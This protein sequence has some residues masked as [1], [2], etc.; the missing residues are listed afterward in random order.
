MRILTILCVLFPVLAGA[1]LFVW[2][3]QDRKLRNRYAITAVGINAV[4]VLTT[5]LLSAVNGADSM[6]VHIADLSP[7]LSIAFRPDGVS[8]VFGCII[9]VLWPVTTVYA[10]SYMEHEG[11]ENMFFGFFL[12]TFG[13]VAGI[14]YSANFFTLYLCYEFMTLV[15]LPLVMHE[16]DDKARAA[17]KKYV[18]YSMTGAAL[19]FIC[20]M[21]FLRYA[22]TLAFRYGGILNMEKVKGHEKEL[23]T[24]FVLGFFG[25]GVKAAIFPF[26][27]WLPTA[28][29]A[30]TPVT[31]LLH[32]VAVVKAGAFAVMRLIYFGFG[33]D[34]LRGTWAQHV[35][36]CAAAFTVMFGT[37]MAL[38]QDHLKRRLAYH[39]V[40]N[41]SYIILGF[42]A[43]SPMGLL[44]GLLHL[45]YH[46]A[47]KITLFFCAGAILHNNGLE[48]V[49][50]MEGIHKKMPVT[51]ATF[52]VAALALMG[53]PPFGAFLSKWTLGVASAASGGFPGVLGAAAL[54]VSAILTT[55]CMMS[56]VIHF[57][58]PTREAP[59][60]P[61][62]FHEADALMK[63]SLLF[64]VGLI[65]LLSLCSAPLC[66]W[67]GGF[68]S[69]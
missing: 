51:A 57:Y 55:L 47:I 4:F 23:M 62:G 48:Y 16:M 3:P 6:A 32:A 12:I 31:A 20:L 38:R 69:C 7:M 50:T 27:H 21:Y 17:G 61:E 2:R 8:L 66:S 28:S 10:F 54:V 37:G 15:T 42:T 49:H 52:T 13:V 39:T 40:S 18:L 68:V 9:G 30:P 34:F 46:S 44:G 5:A 60:L 63:G 58:F 14:A 64:L 29:V 33:C 65:V 11:R 1:A 24:V 19:V 22:D 67:I 35:V 36:M 56:A 41:L 26:H 43:M 45:M 53:V 59:P 25:F